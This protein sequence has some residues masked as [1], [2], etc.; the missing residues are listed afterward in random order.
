V[1][2]TGLLI[3]YPLQTPRGIFLVFLLYQF[4]IASTA[5]E[6]V[7]VQNAFTDY[8]RFLPKEIPLPTFYSREEREILEGTSLSEALGQKTQ[9]LEKEFNMLRERTNGLG[10]ARKAWWGLTLSEDEDDG[11]HVGS[12]ALGFE[13]WKLM[14]AIYRSRALELP[15]DQGIVMVPVLDMANHASDDRYNA[16]FEADGDGNVM[17]LVRDG[18]TISTGDEVS[19]MYGCGGACEMIFSYGFLDNS[20]NSAREVFLGLTIPSDDPLRLAKM[21]FS[22]TAPGVRLYVDQTGQLGWDSDF[23]WW[24]CVN[25]EDGLDFQVLQSVDGQKQLKAVW[26]GREFEANEL[27]TLLLAN[28]LRDVF[29]LRSLVLLQ[30]RVKQQGMRLSDSEEM[31]VRAKH[32]TGVGRST[33]ELINRLRNLELELLTVAFERLETEVGMD[34]ANRT[35][36]LTSHRRQSCSIQRPCADSSRLGLVRQQGQGKTSRTTSRENQDRT[37]RAACQACRHCRPASFDS[38]LSFRKGSAPTIPDWGRIC[39]PCLVRNFPFLVCGDADPSGSP[40][41]ETGVRADPTPI[42]IS[43]PRVTFV[44]AA[45]DKILVAAW[46]DVLPRAW[47]GDHGS[48][49]F[50]RRWRV[51]GGLTSRLEMQ[52]QLEESQSSGPTGCETDDAERGSRGRYNGLLRVGEDRID[53]RRK[54]VFAWPEPD[55]D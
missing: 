39:A 24:A 12:E 50:Q 22:E 2:Q 37:T 47:A 25:E 52:L 55:W 23:V 8:V 34:S 30:Q 21:R 49:H 53:G 16:R 29:V 7:G 32:A 41:S 26:E 13:D 51:R 31:A 35:W 44:E 36:D 4:T 18:K 3:P 46:S 20:T 14:D 45:D 54:E 17:L 42:P 5:Q 43:K 33:W 28:E 10:W 40:N 27:R 9:G 48:P 38:T 19:I 6:I 15:N 1:S 11:Q